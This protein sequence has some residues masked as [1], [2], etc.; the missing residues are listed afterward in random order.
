MALLVPDDSLLLSLAADIATGRL[1]GAL[2]CA[3]AFRHAPT[4]A[5]VAA[6]YTTLECDF[7][8]YSRLPISWDA[9]AIVGAVAQTKATAILG[10]YYDGTTPPQSLWGIFVLAADLTLLYAEDSPMGGILLNS[11][12]QSVPYQP[13]YSRKSTG[14]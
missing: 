11:A 8:G 3:Y 9:P 7:G 4:R 12:G 13:V 14:T 2:L 6:T 1:A 10:W 5:D